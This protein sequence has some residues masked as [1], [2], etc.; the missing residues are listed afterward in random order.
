[1]AAQESAR[2]QLKAKADALGG[3]TFAR[4][5]AKGLK[6]QLRAKRLARALDE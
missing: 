3:A 4:K 2:A 5:G 6:G 1:M